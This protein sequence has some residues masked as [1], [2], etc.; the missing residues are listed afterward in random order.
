MQLFRVE[1]LV[2]EK[3]AR[4]FTMSNVWLRFPPPPESRR[5][6]DV[7]LNEGEKKRGQPPTPFQFSLFVMFGLYS[8]LQGKLVGMRSGMAGDY[9]E[10]HHFND[11]VANKQVPLPDYKS[12]MR[13]PVRAIAYCSWEKE[14]RSFLIRRVYPTYFDFLSYSHVPEGW[15]ALGVMMKEASQKNYDG[16]SVVEDVR[17]SRNVLP[18]LA[19]ADRLKYTAVV[20]LPVIDAE[21]SRLPDVLGAFVFYIGDPGSIPGRDRITRAALTECG[22]EMARAVK[23]HVGLITKGRSLAQIARTR[24][25]GGVLTMECVPRVR[26]ERL[27]EVTAKVVQELGGNEL[28]VVSGSVT[29]SG[30]RRLIYVFGHEDLSRDYV[31]DRVYRAL[32]RC[33]RKGIHYQWTFR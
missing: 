9:V 23:S 16:F 30:R 19:E 12:A 10:R 3:P 21:T 8:H 22:R 2:V 14:R 1:G 32:G 25:D 31:S 17:H 33:H 6:I 5:I 18:Y 20:V 28:F 13:T 4:R 29:N 7:A 26:P 24:T 11:V 15:G 27:E